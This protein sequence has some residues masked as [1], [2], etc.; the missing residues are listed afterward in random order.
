MKPTPTDLDRTA[1]A[2]DGG[3]VPCG[4]PRVVDLAAGDAATAAGARRAGQA[5]FAYLRRPSDGPGGR[6][7]R[8]AKPKSG[9]KVCPAGPHKG[10]FRAM[11]PSDQVDQQ[12][13]CRPEP[14]MYRARAKWSRTRTSRFATRSRSAAD[15]TSSHE[16]LRL[17]GCLQRLRPQAPRGVADGC[18]QV[19]L[20]HAPWHWWGRCQASFIWTQGKIQLARTGHGAIQ[21][22]HD[23]HGA[24]SCRAGA[25]RTGAAV[26]HAP[27]PG[28]RC[29]TLMNQPQKSHNDAGDAGPDWGAH[30]RIDC[31]PGGSQG[32]AGRAAAGRDLSDATRATTSSTC[33]SAVL[34]HLLR[35]FAA[36]RDP[37]GRGWLPLASARRP[38]ATR[39]F[40]GVNKASRLAFEWL[41]QRIRKQ[42]A[43][44][45]A[46]FAFARARQHLREP[47]QD[48]AGPVA[49]PEESGGA[50]DQQQCSRTGAAGF[51][52]KRKL[53]LHPIGRG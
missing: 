15:H 38:A 47:A 31:G 50:A 30:F 1:P 35:D 43:G 44:G 32:L 13:L 18:A 2:G 33:S 12:V 41:Q 45:S 27:E 48:R 34:A 26:A 37:R 20:D 4:H 42:L 3:G 25:G 51:V 8:P 9:R 29:A 16:Y 19:S 49:L 28:S 5:Q 24:R 46:D 11:L 6:G 53:V 22:R 10:Q 7:S 36:H 23:L 14:Q 21:H 17:R 52:I 39:C 40:A